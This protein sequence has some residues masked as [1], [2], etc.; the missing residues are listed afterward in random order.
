MDYAGHRFFRLDDD[1]V[2]ALVANFYIAGLLTVI[3]GVEMVLAKI[4]KRPKALVAVPT[5]AF[6]ALSALSVAFAAGLVHPSLSAESAL[7]LSYSVSMALIAAFGFASFNRLRT[8]LPLLRGFVGYFAVGAGF[9]AASAIANF[10]GDVLAD[11]RLLPSHQVA[12]VGMFLFF[13]AVSI[14]FLAFGKLRG[15][16]GIYDDLAK[17]KA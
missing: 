9:V 8:R 5:A 16:G 4:G 7:P 6:L 17:E 15:F 13:I 12:D 14:M 10:F 3:I 11:A 1:T 2:Q